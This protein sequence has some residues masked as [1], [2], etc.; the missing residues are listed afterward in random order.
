LRTVK[1]L[2]P[3]AE[4][5]RSS[6]HEGDIC[7]GRFRWHVYRQS[8][9]ET[10]EWKIRNVFDNADEGRTGGLFPNI[11]DISRSPSTTSAASLGQLL[12]GYAHPYQNVR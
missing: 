6:E 11:E 1:R 7:R 12:D 9:L 3:N 10:R 5:L 4:D 2:E 8:E